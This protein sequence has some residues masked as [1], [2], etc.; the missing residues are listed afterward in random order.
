M[1]NIGELNKAL[2]CLTDLPTC[3]R[4]P[5]TDPDPMVSA[6]GNWFFPNGTRVPG[7][8]AQWDLHRTRGQIVVVL[9]RRKGGVI[10]IYRCVVP[11]QTKYHN[12]Y[13]GVYTAGSGKCS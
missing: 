9:H 10:G 1:D 7:S 3:C 8:G 6:S 5:Y 11:G 12:L 13:V 4:P 2:S